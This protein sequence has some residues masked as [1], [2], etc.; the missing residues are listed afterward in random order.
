MRR[1]EAP[2]EGD[3]ASVMQCRYLRKP[4]WSPSFATG[5]ISWKRL[6]SPPPG[7]VREA[8]ENIKACIIRGKPGDDEIKRSGLNISWHNHLNDPELSAILLNAKIIVC[9]S[10]Y[11]TIMDL[12]ALK[13]NA[14]LIPTRGQTEQEYL[15]GYFKEKQIAYSEEQGQFDLARALKESEKYNG[16]KNLAKKDSLE[17]RINTILS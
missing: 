2:S 17:K 12:V 9:R 16:F 4:H 13:K 15:A 7:L 14:V 10:G 3:T 8:G 11:S 1:S 5:S 6:A